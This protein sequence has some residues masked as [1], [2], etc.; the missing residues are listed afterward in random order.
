MIATSYDSDGL[1]VSESD[2]AGGAS[3]YYY[4]KDGNV[5]LSISPLGGTTINYF[6]NNGDVTLSIAPTGGTTT[7]YYDA[8][9]DVTL[10][11]FPLNSSTNGT[12]TS[13]YDAYGD[14]TTS[15]DAAGNTTATTYDD[16]G[17]VLTTINP[18]G[19]TVNSYDSNGD[20][21][22]VTSPAGSSS[23][24]YDKA[25]DV[26]LSY[27][28]STGTT[29]N[30][31]DSSGDVT[32]SVN[33]DNQ[34][35]LSYYDKDGDQTQFVDPSGNTTSFQY[36]VAGRVTVTVNPLGTT[37]SYYDA[38]SNVTE[39]VDADGRT[40]LM[41]YDSEDRVLSNV[42]GSFAYNADGEMTSASNANGTYLMQY[43]PAGRVTNVSEPFGVTL[44]FAYDD[45]GNRT[46]LIDSLGGTQMSVY[47]VD[48]RLLTLTYSGQSQSLSET[49][50]YYPDGN[51]DTATLYSGAGLVATE[52]YG[53]GT[54]DQVTSI[55][56]QYAGGSTLASY[57][58]SY[59]AANLMTQTV[60]NGTTTA[61]AYDA[62]GE[63]TTAGAQA[64][65][66]NANGNATN[67]A[68][69]DLTGTDNELTQFVDQAGD[70]FSYGYD[71][72]GNRTLSVETLVG[73]P[74]PET[75][76]YG[77]DKANQM[78][79]ATETIGGTA[80]ETATY[81]YDAFGNLIQEQ[82][83]ESGTT[84]IS[85]YAVDGWNPANSGNLGLAKFTD[86]AILDG[87]NTLVTRE[88]M[89]VGTQAGT[90]T[91]PLMRIDESGATDA[92]GVYYTFTDRM[93][94]VGDVMNSSQTVVDHINYDAWGNIIYQTPGGGVSAAWCS[95]L[96]KRNLDPKAISR[97]V[98]G[99]SL[100]PLIS[101]L[102]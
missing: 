49:L 20:L 83:V 48:D 43:D 30:Y 85:R 76:T 50:S 14:L 92:A 87:S 72:V 66:Y 18:S 52:N 22:G 95:L 44:S 60:E 91:T 40:T 35:S 62:A 4:D 24:G 31:Y 88:I 64:Y 74:I 56:D 73:D 54:N 2:P 10:S 71:A 42:D 99:C 79:S 102:R 59:N 78:T 70:T 41:S 81:G 82:V 11:I 96:L 7:N 69:T 77:Y 33:A 27:S 25:G 28:S 80:I 46:Q 39:T 63:L 47:D 8:N 5:T 1:V 34:T 23:D 75:W 13:Y 84:A 68:N 51:V 94:S 58:Y 97:S 61:Y 53:F 26:T 12:V 16:D 55:L 32:M 45:A 89:S 93:G 38:D 86:L 98:G 15:I 9:G 21:V 6:D 3:T 65:T 67:L 57:D 101:I 29:L 19:T 90:E 36:D 100:L 37:L 17:D